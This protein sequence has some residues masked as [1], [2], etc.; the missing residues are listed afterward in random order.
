MSEGYLQVFLKLF[1]RKKIEAAFKKTASHQYL[2]NLYNPIGPVNFFESIV[3]D[4]YIECTC[5]RSCS[6]CGRYGQRCAN[7]EII[8]CTNCTRCAIRA[9]E[10]RNAQV[11]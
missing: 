11:V 4:G 7:V 9:S 8:V 1:F 2:K 10:E 5:V 6:S 3:S